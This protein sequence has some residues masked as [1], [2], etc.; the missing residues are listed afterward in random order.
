MVQN[1]NLPHFPFYFAD[2]WET[3]KWGWPIYKHPK[4]EL[5][6]QAIPLL[7]E[8]LPFEVYIDDG[9]WR[10]PIVVLCFLHAS[11][12]GATHNHTQVL[13]HD[14][15]GNEALTGQDMKLICPKHM[16]KCA[17]LQELFK[18]VNHSQ[19]MLYVFKWKETRTN[20]VILMFWEENKND[21]GCWTWHMLTKNWGE[22]HK[23]NPDHA[24]RPWLCWIW[25]TCM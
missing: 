6:Y 23:R 17:K 11:A 4:N 15:S 21:C 13:L 1:Q 9:W 16:M 24:G 22:L 10:V 12:W 20:N 7:S 8:P 25:S 18:T 5:K 14:C 2:I 3:A 19:S